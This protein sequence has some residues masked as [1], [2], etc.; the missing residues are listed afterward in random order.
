MSLDISSITDT[1]HIA[2]HP[3]PGHAAYLRSLPTR[4]LLSVRMRPPRPEVRSAAEQWL[5]LP[6]VDSP[7]TP[8]PMLLLFRGV[9]AATPIIAQGGI[10]VVHC[11]YG[12]HRS[13][14]MACC[15]LIGQGY[16]AADAMRLVVQQRAVA[17]PYVWYIRSRI[18]RFADKWT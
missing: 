7:F 10:V 16:T 2:A 13:V 9:E 3:Q 15:I 1:L 17:D 12:R 4:L 18:E 11:H 8:I 5:H 6:C 14:A